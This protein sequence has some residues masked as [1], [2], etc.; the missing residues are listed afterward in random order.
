MVIPALARVLF[1]QVNP[2]GKLPFTI[3]KK[4]SD[5]PPFNS[6]ADTAF[7]GY[8]H[9]YTLL[10][11]QNISPSYPF[12]FGLSYTSF[13]MDNL[14]VHRPKIHPSDY[15]SLSIDIK[16]TGDLAGAEVCQVYI[17]FKHSKIDRPVKLL[18]G[19]QKVFLEPKEKQ[20]LTFRIKAAD[21]AYYNTTTKTWAVEEM[22][23]EVY[24][25]NSSRA[26]A[27]MEGVFRVGE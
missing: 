21:L 24:V 5:F 11:K 1:G 15:L 27:L 17:G 19:F 6:F 22:E 14:Q 18:R 8:Y 3:P 23:Y 10:D 2:S 9:G 20:T 7:Y 25:G 4:A 13:R 16:N 12:G 26:A